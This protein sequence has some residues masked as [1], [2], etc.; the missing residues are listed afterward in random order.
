MLHYCKTVSLFATNVHPKVQADISE[1]V[2]LLCFA[3]L[4]P[5]FSSHS[6]LE[7]WR[8]IFGLCHGAPAFLPSDPPTTGHLGKLRDKFHEHYDAAFRIV[9]YRI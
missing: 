9:V 2:N 6:R 7:S 1:R 8:F 3:S 5:T 4:A